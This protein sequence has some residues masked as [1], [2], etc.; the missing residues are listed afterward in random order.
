MRHIEILSVVRVLI[1]LIPREFIIGTAFRKSVV[2]H[3]Q[4]L[5]VLTHDAGTYL[6]IRIF[7]AHRGKLRNSHEIFVPGNISVS[8]L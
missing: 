2:A 3:G 4:D 1:H 6:R 5:I 8:L 7:G